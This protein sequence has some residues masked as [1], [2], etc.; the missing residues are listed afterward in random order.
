MRSPCPCPPMVFWKKQGPIEKIGF[1]AKNT[2]FWNNHFLRLTMFRQSIWNVVKTKKYRF[3][4]WTLV[5][6]HFS[7][8]CFGKKWIFGPFCDF[9]PNAKTVVSPFLLWG[10]PLSVTFL[11]RT[12]VSQSSWLDYFEVRLY[13]KSGSIFWWPRQSDRRCISAVEEAEGSTWDLSLLTDISNAP[14]LSRN[15]SIC[16][17]EIALKINLKT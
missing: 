13:C 8:F 2:E 16:K 7:T 9:G 3:P 10:R 17:D 4:K 14:N 11:F 6:Y 12:S 1:L 15:L 5:S